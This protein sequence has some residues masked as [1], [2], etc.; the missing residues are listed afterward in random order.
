MTEADNEGRLFGILN[1]SNYK[2]IR[3]AEKG[4][5]Y[6]NTVKALFQWL[7]EESKKYKADFY[8]ETNTQPLAGEEVEQVWQQ[9]NTVLTEYK[10]YS[11]F[12]KEKRWDAFQWD[13]IVISLLKIVNMPYVH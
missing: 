4:F 3:A 2:N 1:G 7:Q 10:N 5:I 13:V 9:I 12:F 11:A 6:R 8:K